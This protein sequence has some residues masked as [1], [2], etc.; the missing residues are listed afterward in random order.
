MEFSIQILPP[1]HLP[2]MEKNIFFQQF[3]F[4]FIMFIIAKFGENF[5]DKIDICFF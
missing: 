1:P 4:V 3:F 5:E 2:S